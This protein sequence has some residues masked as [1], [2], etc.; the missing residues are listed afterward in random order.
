MN[1]VVRA[2]SRELRSEE[3]KLFSKVRQT[4][5]DYEPLRASH[6]EIAID[7]LGSNVRLSGRTRTLPQKEMAAVLVQRMRD[8]QGVS[9]EIISDPEV[10]RTVAS[11]LAEDERTAPY[12]LSVDARHGVVF[13]NGMV[14]S[15]AARDAA[16]EIA[17]SA[18]FV[19]AVRSEITIG[20]PEFPRYALPRTEAS[21]LEQPLALPEAAV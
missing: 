11:A 13:L 4:L 6:A 21:A 2:P 12:T 14:P 18:R 1:W 15:E 9:N 10:V 17:A 3:K 8:V 19:L 7:I 5:W 20:G 16:L